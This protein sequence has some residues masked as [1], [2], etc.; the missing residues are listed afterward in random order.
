MGDEN[1]LRTQ[2]E[3]WRSRARERAETI[4]QLNELWKAA[5]DE[6]TVC[7]ECGACV[8][9]DCWV[10]KFKSRVLEAGK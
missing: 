8:H 10:F 1:A 4:A 6:C 7:E 3:Y 5:K 9:E 2:V